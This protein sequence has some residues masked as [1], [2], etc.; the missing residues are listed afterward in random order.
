MLELIP[1]KD[2]RKYIEQTGRTFTDFEKAAILYQLNLPFEKMQSEL[3]RIMET[4]DDEMLK[5]QISERIEYNL[6]CVNYF[7]DNTEGYIYAVQSYEYEEPYISGYFSNPD[8]AYS[9]GKKKKCKFDIEKYPI[10]GANGAEPFKPRAYINPYL[11][12]SVEPEKYIEEQEYDGEYIASFHF[13]EDGILLDFCSSE[14]EYANQKVYLR[15]ENFDPSRFENTYLDVPNPFEKGDIVKLTTDGSYGIVDTSQEEWNRY[16]EKIKLSEYADF[17]DS[18]ITIKFISEDGSV[19]HEHIN[20]MFLEKCELPEGNLKE[21][22]LEL[23]H[24]R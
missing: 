5:Q 14:M 8:L 23:R 6:S 11:F 17:V 19:D 22:F 4:T 16:N 1:S 3:K 20:P 7:K 13:N 21:R 18:T 2:V 24:T 9:H 10:I 12:D 15:V